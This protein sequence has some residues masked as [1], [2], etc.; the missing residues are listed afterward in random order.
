MQ[1]SRPPSPGAAETPRILEIK[2][3]QTAPP[4]VYY[5][6]N[7]CWCGAM[8]AQLICNQWVAGSTPVTS[9][10]KRPGNVSF[11]VFFFAVIHFLTHS[12]VL[13]NTCA[14]SR[15]PESSNHMVFTNGSETETVPWH[16]EVNDLLA[17]SRHPTLSITV[18]LL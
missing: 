9:S 3:C 17:G 14:V 2:P 15:K 18:D 4:V 5:F 13:Q 1:R 8:A 12:C 7:L 10:K 11:W 6:S 16:K